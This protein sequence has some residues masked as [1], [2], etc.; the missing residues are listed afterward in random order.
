MAISDAQ[1]VLFVA[2]DGEVLRRL[3]GAVDVV[4]QVDLLSGR[5][6]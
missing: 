1:G 6:L 2:A 5:S 4:A 3:C